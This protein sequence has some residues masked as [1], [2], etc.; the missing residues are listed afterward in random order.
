[1]PWNFCVLFSFG[2]NEETSTQFHPRQ[3]Y[4]SIFNRIEYQL[5]RYEEAL[6]FSLTKIF[7][8]ALIWNEKKVDQESSN[9]RMSFPSR[10]Q[11]DKCEILCYKCLMPFVCVDAV[12]VL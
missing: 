3:N 11:W 12:Y 10:G 8:D 4:T 5:M 6:H 7:R 1:M 2:G 9:G